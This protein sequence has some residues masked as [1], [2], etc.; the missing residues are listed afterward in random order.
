[1]TLSHFIYCR[2]VGLWARFTQTLQQ[3]LQDF[4]LRV[5]DLHLRLIQILFT[6][7][8]LGEG[9]NDVLH[10]EPELLPHHGIAI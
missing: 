7:Q 8:E 4:A 2:K 10:Q 9:L 5:L 6:R 3:T 1:M